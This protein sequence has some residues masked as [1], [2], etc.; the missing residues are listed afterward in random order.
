MVVLGE[1]GGSGMTLALPGKTLTAV[2]GNDTFVASF[3]P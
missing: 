1:F 2:S 3:A